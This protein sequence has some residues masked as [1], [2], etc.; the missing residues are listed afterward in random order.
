MSYFHPIVLTSQVLCGIIIIIIIIIIL[1][2]V[3][4]IIIIIIDINSVI[5][6]A[7]LFFSEIFLQPHMFN[8]LKHKMIKNALEYYVIHQHYLT[9]GS[10]ALP[11]V[12]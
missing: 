12:P 1:M 2:I 10:S 7:F 8:P 11:H 4:M 9:F 5:Y 3:I 6:T